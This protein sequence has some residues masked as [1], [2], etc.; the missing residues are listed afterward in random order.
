MHGHLR[1]V[2]R[3]HLLILYLIMLT[4]G[5]A[6]FAPSDGGRFRLATNLV[7]ASSI[8]LLVITDCRLSGRSLLR[9][10]QELFFFTWPV[11][12]FVYCLRSR[13]WRGVGLLFLHT[14]GLLATYYVAFFVTRQ[15]LY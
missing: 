2:C 3:G 7:F 12:I 13:G 4:E 8:T 5:L 9:I 15:L 10:V 11:A 6:P 1:M 14:V